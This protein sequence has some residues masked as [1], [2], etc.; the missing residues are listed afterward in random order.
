MP[1][2]SAVTEQSFSLSVKASGTSSIVKI[3]EPIMTRCSAAW[4]YALM[5]KTNQF[6]FFSICEL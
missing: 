3:V 2:T 5:D 4:Y 1:V 6:S